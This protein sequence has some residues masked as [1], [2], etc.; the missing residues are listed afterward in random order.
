MVRVFVF[1]QLSNLHADLTRSAK[2]H[3]LRYYFHYTQILL[4]VLLPRCRPDNN[5]PGHQWLWEDLK[6]E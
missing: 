4:T 5:V 3:V 6:R 2:N 1:K